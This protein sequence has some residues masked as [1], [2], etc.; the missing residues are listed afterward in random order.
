M[1]NEDIAIKLTDHENAIG[2]LKHR[3]KDVED[4]QKALT[5]LTASVRERSLPG[6]WPGCRVCEAQ[7]GAT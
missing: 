6:W 3:M 4:N 2:S 1:T 5:D 7:K